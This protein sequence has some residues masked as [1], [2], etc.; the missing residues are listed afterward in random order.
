MSLP[1]LDRIR[2]LPVGLLGM[3]AL[4]AACESFLAWNEAKF[5]RLEAHDWKTSLQAAK[6]SGQFGGILCLGDS[7]IKFGLLPLVLES[8]VGQ[9]VECLAVMGGQ[10]PST[11]FL[12]KKA[13]EAGARPSALVV[14]WEP[15]LLK[16]GVDHNARMWPELVDVGD[17]LGLSWMSRDGSGFLGRLL[18]GLLPS[19]RERSEIRDNIKAALN[20]QTPQ[21]P[22]WIER[23]WRNKVMNRGATALAKDHIGRTADLTRWGNKVATRWSVDPVNTAYARK[24][25]KLADAYKIPVFITIMPVSPGMQQKYEQ[26]GIDQPY[27]EWVKKL[28]HRFP[29][30]VVVD[31]R[32]SNY[33]ASVFYDPLHLDRDGAVSASIA[34]GGYLREHLDGQPVG[35]RWVQMPPYR[36]STADV[37][38]EDTSQSYQI[39]TRPGRVR[40]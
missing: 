5:T 24:F 13:L 16:D 26:N 33:D 28:N 8:K 27:T 1:S 17:N 20:G 22:E 7:Q 3:I 18:A 37:A 29:N 14:D 32:H 38:F 6:T 25:L 4:I 12:L 30:V 34:L 15:H 21:M 39:M 9:P 19:I 36:P 31:L 2:R 11:Y 35:E 40:R 10:A 23:S